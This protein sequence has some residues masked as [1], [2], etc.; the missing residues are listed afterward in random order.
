MHSWLVPSL[1]AL[2]FWGITGVTQKVSTNHISFEMSFVWFTAAFFVLSALIGVSIPLHWHL[3]AR[4]VFGAAGGGL[5]NGLGVIT[6]F[7]ALERGGKAS[8]VIPLVSIYPL[9][10]IAGAWFLLGERLSARQFAGI[11][12]ALVGAVLLS[13]EGKPQ[14][15]VEAVPR[16]PGSS[17][18]PTSR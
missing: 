8:V 11:I 9:V 5:L 18:K 12:C 15:A 7:A 10:T 4:V 16:D 2:V 3:S 6:S 1:L 17:E 14:V 13:R